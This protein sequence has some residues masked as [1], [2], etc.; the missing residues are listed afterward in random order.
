MRVFFIGLITTFITL[1]IAASIIKFPKDYGKFFMAA[2]VY[3]G[4]SA[5][6]IPVPIIGI[7]IPPVGMYMVLVGS[8]YQSHSWVVKLCIVS[9]IVNVAMLAALITLTN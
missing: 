4:L 1:V 2:V 7:F 8:N 6:P 9:F 5:V 3:G